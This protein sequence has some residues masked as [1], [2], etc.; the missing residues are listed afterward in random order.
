MKTN[1][2]KNEIDEIKKWEEKIKREDLICSSNKFE[3]DFQ[4]HEAIRSFGES[5]YTGKI[6]TDEAEIDQSNLLK[7]L[8]EF[9][10]RSRART[11]DGKDKNRNTFESANA[12]YR[13]RE[14]ILDAF[15]SGI[16]PIKETQGKGLTILTLKQMLQRLPIALAQ[17][18]A[19]NI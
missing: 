3:Y 10:D 9:N 17:V 2:I 18:K 5:I 11:T 15:K 14:L 13:G 8:M 4:Q 6:N 12:R 1:E 16:F 7:N 19:D